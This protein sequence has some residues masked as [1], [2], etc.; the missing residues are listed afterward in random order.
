MDDR[1]RRELTKLHRRRAPRRPVG[2]RAGGPAAGAAR[3]VARSRVTAAVV[4]FA[5]FG[6][7]A[8]F[9]GGRSR[10]PRSL[11]PPVRTW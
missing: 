7:A 6:L 1:Y 5:V 4:A 2:S 10:R 9:C 3:P 11:S 8:F